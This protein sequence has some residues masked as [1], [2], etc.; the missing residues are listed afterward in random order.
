M[1]MVLSGRLMMAL[2]IGMM[3]IV[4]NHSLMMALRICVLMISIVLFRIMLRS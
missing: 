4:L 3:I 2:R 1:M